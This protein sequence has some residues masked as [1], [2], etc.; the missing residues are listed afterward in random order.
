V[1]A[2][3][4]P[5]RS[6]LPLATALVIVA[7]NRASSGDHAGAETTAGPRRVKCASV[8]EQDIEDSVEIRG[9]V[10]P[11]FGKDALIA[12][13]VAGRVLRV[14]VR[15]GDRVREGQELARIDDA[16][17]ADQSRQADAVIA[18]SE[19]ETELARTTEARVRRVFDRGIAAKQDLDDASARSATARAGEAEARAAGAI[20]HRGLARASVRSPLAGVVLKVFRKSGELVDGTPATPVVEVGDPA[21]L[22]L[23]ATVPAAEL[24]QIRGTATARVDLPVMPGRHLAGHVSLVS[25]AVD[26]LTGLGTVRVRLDLK[27]VVGPPIGVTGTA[28]INVGRHRRRS[29][30]PVAALR[31]PNGSQAEIALCGRDGRAH[32]V[33]VEVGRE[34][35]GLVEISAGGA[36]AGT[37]GDTD[38]SVRDTLPTP[39]PPAIEVGA[40]VIVD[41]VLGIE[42]GDPILGVP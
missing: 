15:E 42:D 36:G 24:V 7:C 5:P 17:L 27:G 19:A 16:T 28:R 34:R 4:L 22:E 8:V 38:T 9:T 1:R 11:L 41:P 35:S 10:A 20:A 21:Q 33:R 3:P 26:R 31:A 25:P 2:D 6:W 23:V 29:L 39:T 40:L 18:K 14:L 32:V 30:V 37:D 13:Q 12:P